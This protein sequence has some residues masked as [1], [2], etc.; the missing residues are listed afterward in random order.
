MAYLRSMNE[1]QTNLDSIKAAEKILS[2]NTQGGEFKNNP[3]DDI[4]SINAQLLK[5]HREIYA[6][7]R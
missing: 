3:V 2:V 1:I 6:L 4:R 5:Y 7:Q